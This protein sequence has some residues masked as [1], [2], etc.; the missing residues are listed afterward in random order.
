ME[1]ENSG[2]DGNDSNECC[3]LQ[4]QHGRRCGIDRE[5]GF[6]FQ[7]F[8]LELCDLGQLPAS[9]GLIADL[10]TIAGVYLVRLH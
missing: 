10:I 9:L 5:P 2:H 8:Y 4:D 1:S 7:F 3:A 6:K